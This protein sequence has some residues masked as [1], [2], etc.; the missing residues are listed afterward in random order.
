MQ[1]QFNKERTDFSTNGT[2]WKNWTSTHKKVTSTHTSQCIH[3][4]SE[5]IIDLNIK[6]KI[7]KL[8]EEDIEEKHLGIG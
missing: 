6:P 5:W 8:L 3:I 4:N 7:I 1:R 2:A